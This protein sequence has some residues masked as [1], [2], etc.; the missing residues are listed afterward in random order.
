MRRYRFRYLISVILSLS[1]AIICMICVNADYQKYI[2]RT[3]EEKL[4]PNETNVR[5]FLTEDNECASISELV[6]ILQDNGASNISFLNEYMVTAVCDVKVLEA[7]AEKNISPVEE[8]E[9][10]FENAIIMFRLEDYPQFNAIEDLDDYV[11]TVVG[12][13]ETAILND[14]ELTAGFMPDITEEAGQRSDHVLGQYLGRELRF[15][16][17][18]SNPVHDYYH[19]YNVYA[20]AAHTDCRIVSDTGERIAYLCPGSS[21]PYN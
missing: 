19:I 10:D 1:L 3:D 21:C 4:I 12:A 8:K 18:I 13:S 9:L 11:R 5:L 17:H 2:A 16:C 6:S 15:S 20:C 7:L 14:S